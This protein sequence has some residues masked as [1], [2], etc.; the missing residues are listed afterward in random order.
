MEDMYKRIYEPM[1]ENWNTYEYFR[2]QLEKLDNTSS[3][4]YPY[5]REAA[6]VGA[7]LGADGLGHYD[8]VKVQRLWY[9]VQLVMSGRYQHWFRAFVKDEPHKKAKA[10]KGAW[11]LIIAAGLPV[12]MVWRMCY[13]WQNELLNSRPYDTPS[14]HGLV[15]C[16]G[17]WR[18]F[19]AYVNTNQLYYSRDIS[20]WDVNSPG[21][22]FKVVGMWRATWPGVTDEWRRVH[23]MLF[24]DAYFSS[25]IL[26]SNGLVVQQQF[27][28][29]MKS[30]VFNTITDNT[31][32]MVG[33]HILACLRS[34]TR[35]GSIAATGDDVMQSVINDTYL[36]CLEKLGCRVKEVLNH[37]EFMGTDYRNGYPE[38][39]YFEKH[40]V[41]FCTKTGIEAE[42]LDAYC[43]L[44]VYSDKFDFWQSIAQKLGVSTRSSTYYRFWYSSP[45][46]RVL[47]AAW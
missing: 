17:G 8:E 27:G 14:K 12:Q 45:L 29:Y 41:A 21:W 5:M 22:V 7:W 3:P 13:A 18:R 25:K 26:F 2:E 11:R 28:G 43:R 1:P 9:D 16:Y 31:L 37:V 10:E 30:G 46:A 19:L 44:Y 39:M 38:P 35:I 15:F 33:M 4:G 23:N 24:E 34:N 36:G 6:T 20:A 40:L 47:K 32:A 42:V